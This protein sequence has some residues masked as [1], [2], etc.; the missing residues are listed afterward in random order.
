[1]TYLI[2]LYGYIHMGFFGLLVGL[3][4]EEAQ[5][6]KHYLFLLLLSL[7]W[8]LIIAWKLTCRKEARP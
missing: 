3:A 6:W 7:G 8:P 4:A 2:L 1:M 5:H